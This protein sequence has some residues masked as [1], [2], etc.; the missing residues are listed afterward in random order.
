MKP[1][2]DGDILRYEVGF[3]AEFMSEDGEPRIRGWEFI[4]E[5]LDHL[6]HIIC[7]EAWGDEPPCIYLTADE[8][9]INRLNKFRVKRDEELLKF[10]PN[11]RLETATVKVYKGNRAKRE[12]PFY[13]DAITQYLMDKY[14]VKLA[15]G[16]EADDLLSI[17]AYNNYDVVV[18]SRD[19]DLRITP[20]NHYGWQCGKQ[21]QFGPVAIDELGF[22]EYNG[23]VI[24]GGGLKFFYSQ[25][26]T[27]DTTDNYPGLPGCG[28]VKVMSV[29]PECTDEES[30]HK[31]V[32]SLY[33]KKYGDT[34]RERMLEQC[35]LAWMV[36][37]VHE[38]GSPVMFKL[39]DE[40]T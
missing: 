13:F 29:L 22:I 30:L 8:A 3:Y 5:K 12:R 7:E 32:A 24:K 2:I 23:K 40:R 37:G 15:I 35:Q 17:D 25:V 36:R 21:P 28:P 20:T 9:L 33:E 38:D 18:C 16:I 11:F 27:G 10:I 6:I 1:L 4:E 14:E 26:L 34:W 31:A 19:K 39:F